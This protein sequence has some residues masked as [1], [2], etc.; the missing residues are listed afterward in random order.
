MFAS[1]YLTKRNVNDITAVRSR[2]STYSNINIQYKHCQFV[3]FTLDVIIETV[4]NDLLFICEIF[5]TSY[6][7]SASH[8]NGRSG[9]FCQVMDAFQL[10][11]W[12]WIFFLASR[13]QIHIILSQNYATTMA[14]SVVLIKSFRVKLGEM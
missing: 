4:L 10:K 3:A 12:K 6:L 14:F 7:S 9:I 2:L 13:W 1:Q 5:I 8:G 11:C